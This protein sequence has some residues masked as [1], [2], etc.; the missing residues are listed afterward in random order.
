[1]NNID[2]N[3]HSNNSNN[4]KADRFNEEE[5]EQVASPTKSDDAEDFN[6]RD[7]AFPP[8][9]QE[10]PDFLGEERKKGKKALINNLFGAAVDN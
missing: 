3:Y 5:C 2:E 4:L 1:M 9:D 6:N 8:L 10:F 7:S